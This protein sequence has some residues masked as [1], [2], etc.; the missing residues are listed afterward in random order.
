MNGLLACE[1]RSGPGRPECHAK[2]AVT[3]H[4]TSL[5]EVCGPAPLVTFAREQAPG[6]GDLSNL[7]EGG[8][9]GRKAAKGKN[10]T[11]SRSY[12]PLLFAGLLRPSVPASK[13]RENPG[14][15][16]A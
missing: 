13:R 5:R 15:C 2:G 11:E 16:T 6:G 4:L 8:R 9:L 3:H 14:N 12:L 10:M 7:Q 1:A